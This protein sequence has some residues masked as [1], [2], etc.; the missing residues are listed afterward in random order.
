MKQFLTMMAFAGY[1]TK[2]VMFITLKIILLA[3]A[4]AAQFVVIV[5]GASYL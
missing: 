2:D 4:L 5:I 1:T 3:V